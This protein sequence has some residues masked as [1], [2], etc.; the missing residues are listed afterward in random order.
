LKNTLSSDP[1]VRGGEVGGESDGEDCV[2]GR[3]DGQLLIG[4]GGE[5]E[6]GAAEDLVG[7]CLDDGYVGWALVWDGKYGLEGDDLA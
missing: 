3:K 6:E 4:V 1:A 5:G 7:G 2:V